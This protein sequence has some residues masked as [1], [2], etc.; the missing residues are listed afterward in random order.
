[1]SRLLAANRTAVGVRVLVAALGFFTIVACGNRESRLRAQQAS[2][3]QALRTG[4]LKGA[5]S[6]A[7]DGL[8]TA[9][10]AKDPFWVWTFRLLRAESLVLQVRADAAGA[11]LTD[12]IP[13]EER[14]ASLRARQAYLNARAS[15]ARGDLARASDLV[16]QGQSFKPTGDTQLDLSVLAGQIRLRGGERSGAESALGDVI[17]QAAAATDHYHQALA[18]NDLGMGS[19]VRNRFDEA[20]VSFDRVLA[21]DDL[22][23]HTIYSVSLYN[24]GICYMQLGDY[25]KAISLQLRAVDFQERLGSPDRLEQA[26]GELGRTY[27]AAGDVRNAVTHLQRAFDLAKGAHLDSDAV[28]WASALADAYIELGEWDHAATFNDQAIALRHDASTTKAV[29][30]TLYAAKIAEGRGQLVD[31]ERLF[32]Q[33]AAASAPEP[34]VSWEANAGLARVALRRGHASAASASFERA[35][36]IIERTR[37]DLRKTDYKLSYLTSLIRFYR[38]YVDA[39]ISLG[40]T[41]RAL[42]VADSSR[43]RVLAERQRTLS[44]ARVGAAA[45]RAAVQRSG[46]VALFY[47]LQPGAS[48]LWVVRPADIQ[49]VKLPPSERIETLVRAYQKTI[50]SPLADPLRSGSTPGD[51]LYAA[52]VQPAARWIP[53]T[54]RLLVVPDGALHGLNFETLP[55]D[56]PRRHYW[57]EDVEIQ[58]VPSLGL[59]TASANAGRRAST[60][61]SPSLLLIGS[62]AVAD[63]QFPALSYASSEMSKVA[64]HFDASHVVSLDGAGA[65]P[66]AYHNASP[67]RFSMIHF[68]AH[69]T[70]NVES[71][72]DSAV[73][74]ASAN[75][76]YKLYA[77]DIAD[78]DDLPLQAVLVTV[79]ACRGAGERAY[80]GEGLIG[81]A[82]AF[83]RAGAR[84]VIAGLWDVDDQSTADLMD[85]LYAGLARGE[86]PARALR[87]AKLTQLASTG[88]LARPY[89]WGPFELF[90]V[91]P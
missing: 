20:L 39:L 55:I 74:L 32:Q 87:N 17:D 46:S 34:T 5:I 14:F 41:D 25:A 30:N 7:E 70:A 12:A 61:S 66:A 63:P 62:P 67:E 89:Y 77:R 50:A 49:L 82:W 11:D 33:T 85:T 84:R 21:L 10:A 37:S 79:S 43:G 35:L 23:A 64:A 91:S 56:G 48:W 16:Q 60:E 19:L 45:F 38:E 40:M 42:E 44:P 80:S 6:L 72:L 3:V 83:L 81:F 71:P 86:P 18:L 51:E 22:K 75:G 15:V 90:T 13:T 57:I 47:W 68:T 58:T 27:V 4:N 73:I 2:C 65:S 29:W 28:I 31:A 36:S 9:S 59:L 69:A 54:G 78:R 8:A 1:M 24:A 52:L 26:V 76:A 88:A 53:K